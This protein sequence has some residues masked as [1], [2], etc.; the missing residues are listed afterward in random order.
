MNILFVGDF[1]ASHPERI[2]IGDKLKQLIE[3]CQLRVLNFEGPLKTSTPNHPNNTVLVQSDK[4]PLWCKSFGFNVISLANNHML[5]YGIEG[6]LKSYSAFDKNTTIGFGKWDEA[7]SVNYYEVNG[8]RIGLSAASSADLASLKD[9]Y[10]DL[11]KYGCAWV[12]HPKYNEII[13]NAK[14][15]C[16]CLFCYIHAGAEFMN[17]PLPEW[18]TRYKSLI[19]L[20]AD[21]VIASHPHVPQGW[22][23][24]KDKP[25]VYSLGN[26]IFDTNNHH[27]LW[28]KGLVAKLSV[29]INQN[30]EISIIP[31]NK[32]DNIVEIDDSLS[33]MKHLDSLSLDITD[34]EYIKKIDAEIASLYPKY[35]NWMLAGF[36][37]RQPLRKGLGS[38]P[39]YIYRALN[40][41]RPNYKAALHNIREEST[42]YVLQRAIKNSSDIYL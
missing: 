40:P 29:N 10:T 23:L 33:T 28:N 8:I 14:K 37:L 30:T 13:I 2:V 24:Y 9:E 31:I 1:C 15:E 32:N 25:I 20:G 38:I 16:D 36:G 12:N 22:E 26:F 27:P 39:R 5:D 3:S 41:I 34:E 35:L 4:S 7:Y 11:D 42:I 19:D 17:F 18:R 21:G 6:A